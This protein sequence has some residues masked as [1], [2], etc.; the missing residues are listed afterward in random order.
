MHS[1][2][3][4]E[5]APQQYSLAYGLLYGFG[6][7][8]N[9]DHASVTTF[10]GW[11]AAL[12]GFSAM[13][14]CWWCEGAFTVD[15]PDR[16]LGTPVHIAIDNE[17]DG[18][19]GRHQAGLVQSWT[20]TTKPTL[21]GTP[22]STSEMSSI[23][24]NPHRAV[25]EERAPSIGGIIVGSL[26]PPDLPSNRARCVSLGVP[27]TIGNGSRSSVQKG[28][29][30]RHGGARFRRGRTSFRHEDA[31][32]A[33]SRSGAHAYWR[34]AAVQ[35]TTSSGVWGLELWKPVFTT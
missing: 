30:V 18:E 16:R 4:P 29:A 22:P 17:Y 14:Q 20:R 34:P 5:A 24:P 32:F 12:L 9:R 27:F 26:L 23:G 3:A 6:S 10:G 1:R 7:V 21:P 35:G 2:K 25:G 33:D 28:V 31:D 19:D 11:L 8:N 15:A 13:F